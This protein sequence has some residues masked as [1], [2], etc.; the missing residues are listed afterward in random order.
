MLSILA[1]LAVSKGPDK[2]NLGEEGQTAIL[3]P[4]K[5]ANRPFELTSP[6]TRLIR[7]YRSQRSNSAF[8]RTSAASCRATE[9]LRRRSRAAV[10]RR[11]GLLLSSVLPPYVQV[12]SASASQD[13]E[14]LSKQSIVAALRPRIKTIEEKNREL[15]ALLELA[16][17]NLALPR[18]GAR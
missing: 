15:T 7:T 9:A 16:Y 13:R 5:R 14:R 8:S 17:G 11:G 1:I 12:P 18:E 6:V 2:P 3:S 10:G 4:D